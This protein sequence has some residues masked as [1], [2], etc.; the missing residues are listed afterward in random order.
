MIRE[1]TG[2]FVVSEVAESGE[3]SAGVVFRECDGQN[4]VRVLAES[5]E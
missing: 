5:V 4:D 3:G 1:L 2:E